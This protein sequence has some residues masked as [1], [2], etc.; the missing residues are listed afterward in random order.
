VLLVLL[1]FITGECPAGI[2]TGTCSTLD[3]PVVPLRRAEGEDKADPS[4][5]IL[6][7]KAKAQLVRDSKEKIDLTISE[8]QKVSINF[9]QVREPPAALRHEEATPAVFLCVKR[10]YGSLVDGPCQSLGCSCPEIVWLLNSRACHC[11]GEVQTCMIA[12]EI[13]KTVEYDNMRLVFNRFNSVVAFVPT[14]AT[15][16]SPEVTNPLGPW[17]PGWVRVGTLTHPGAPHCTWRRGETK[18]TQ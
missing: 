8:T 17:A 5:V 12:D 15:V 10:L 1:P 13:L 4:F 3:V 11:F 16:L 9:T 7:E 2:A 14:V 18:L 6:G